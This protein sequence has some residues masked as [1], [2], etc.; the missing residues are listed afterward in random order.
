MSGKLHTECIG[1]RG[2]LLSAGA[3][4]GFENGGKEWK[5]RSI[6]GAVRKDATNFLLLPHL[7]YFFPNPLHSMRQKTCCK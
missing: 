7:L 4:C 2:S 5:N 1:L 6:Y 3:D